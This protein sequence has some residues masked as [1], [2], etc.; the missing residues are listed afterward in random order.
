MA[1]RRYGQADDAPPI[2]A[3]NDVYTGLLALSLFSL[4]VSCLLLFIDWY[5]YGSTPPEKYSLPPLP[6]V[7]APAAAA[8]K[9][10]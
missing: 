1:A 7:K 6:G 10:P 3:R 9:Q 2:K 8:P 4:V 5:G